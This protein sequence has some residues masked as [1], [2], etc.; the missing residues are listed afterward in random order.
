MENH[1]LLFE[2]GVE[3]MP[4]KNLRHISSAFRNSVVEMLKQEGLNYKVIDVFFTPRR[5]ALIIHEL[6]ASQKDKLVVKL[7]PNVEM[8]YNEEDGT[9]TNAALGFAKSCGVKFAELTI[10]E[11]PKGNKLSFICEKKGKIVSEIM[12]D[13]IAKSLR[14]LPLPKMMRWG[15]G[16]I[17]FIRPVQWVILMFGSNIIDATFFG[18]DTSD[19]TYGHRFLS[20]K[21]FKIKSA[22]SYEMQLNQHYVV[23]NPEDRLKKIKSELDTIS[24]SLSA[25]IIQDNSLLDE[26][27]SLVEYPNAIC[28]EFPNDYLRVPKEALIKSMREHQKCFSMIDSNG[29]LINRFITI[30]NIAP[31]NE[32]LIVEGNIKV[33]N[34]R[35]ADAAF[36]FDVDSKVNLECYTDRLKS[37]TFQSQL[38]S[39]MDKTKRI[40]SLAGKITSELGGNIAFA[41][42]AGLLS[43]ADLMTNMVKEFPDLQGIM[44]EYY[45]KSSG[46]VGEVGL[47]ISE[48]YLPRYSGDNIPKKHTSVSLALA[49]KLDTLIGI[50]GVGFRPTGDKDPFALRRAALGILRIIKENKIPLSLEYLIDITMREYS[51]YDLQ[52]NTKE[53][54]YIFFSE[55]LKGIFRD[56]GYSAQEFN[57]VMQVNPKNIID[58]TKRIEGVRYFSKMPSSQTL[59]SANKR[60]SNLLEKNNIEED[61]I[62]DKSLMQES[63]ELVL[64]E[65]IHC[66]KQEIVSYMNDEDYIKVL[67]CLSSIE[68][69]I[70]DFFDHIMVMTED[71][72]LRNNRLALLQSAYNLFKKVADIS[73]LSA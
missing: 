60:V 28:C 8:A 17:Q 69:P 71:Q 33:M 27:N 21:K 25:E 20:P 40:S 44:G 42:R 51:G 55:R 9:P 41:V 26:V 61:L 7:G 23:V 10:K 43:K 6:S 47:A 62:V 32:K 37:V 68:K 73:A 46:E 14:K 56:E 39:L 18:K 16:D 30:S 35:L 19:Y 64:F 29:D 58:F 57:A 52:E 24:E 70:N 72:V 49:D 2:L 36:F 3:E 63:A 12:P 31:E 5:I 45:A 59:A 4:A 15:Y 67:S 13:I 34:A 53:D 1:D 54:V 38:G 11:T 48:H 66:C 65:H 22:K 50:F